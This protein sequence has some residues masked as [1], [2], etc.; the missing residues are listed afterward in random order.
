M[1]NPPLVEISLEEEYGGYREYDPV[2][3]FMG[4]RADKVEIPHME[5]LPERKNHQQHEAAGGSAQMA[6]YSDQES[7]YQND[8]CRKDGEIADDKCKDAG[9]EHSK[10][11]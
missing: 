7:V 8:K 2:S 4:I 1:K 3:H 11:D 6:R 10:P 5:K 9:T